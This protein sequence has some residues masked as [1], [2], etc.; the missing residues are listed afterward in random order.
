[1]SQTSIKLEARSLSRIIDGHRIVDSVS[2]RVF[3][4]DV[5]AIL[6]P[7]GAGKSTLLRLLNRLDEP[8][9]GTVLLDGEDYREL[10]P[11][12]LRH[13]VGYIPQDPALRDGTVFD[14]VTIGP[15]LRE[16]PV[17]EERVEELLA[18]MD[19]AGYGSREVTDLSGGE[20]QRVAI[21]RTLITEPEILLLDEPTSSLDATSESG[22]ETLLTKS[23]HDSGLTAI[24][25]T[26][27]MAQARRLADRVAKL[28]EGRLTSIG[29][30]SEVIS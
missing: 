7:S 23:I 20:A 25:V 28:E 19:L 11:R 6:G 18:Q 9:E 27:D 3:E 8:S 24:L 13:R 30:V 16:E 29:S 1:M 12:E 15:R 22:V 26:H 2:F 14:N 17:S 5:L 10:P 21:A 4:C